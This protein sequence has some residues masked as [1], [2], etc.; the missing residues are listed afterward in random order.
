MSERTD[1][2]DPRVSDA[3]RTFAD[4]QTPDHLDKAVMR[5]AAKANRTPYAAARAWMRP[6]AWAAVIGLSLVIVLELTL[7]PQE[8]VT[9]DVAPDDAAPPV[10]SQAADEGAGPVPVKAPLTETWRAR[11]LPATATAA[12][13]MMEVELGADLDR[14]LQSVAAEYLCPAEVRDSADSWHDC[15]ES[16]RETT[17]ANRIAAELERLFA[18]YPEFEVP[19]QEK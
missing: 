7:L 19:T 6:A 16:L 14:G 1:H 12:P 11:K 17:P 3:Y 9:Y 2:S 18:A 15:I 8:S 5:M 13:T 10:D 4:E